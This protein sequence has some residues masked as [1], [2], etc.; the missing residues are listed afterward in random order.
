MHAINFF[1]FLLIIVFPSKVFMFR[2]E[3]VEAKERVTEDLFPAF[4]FFLAS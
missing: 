2:N 3:D 4:A 1:E